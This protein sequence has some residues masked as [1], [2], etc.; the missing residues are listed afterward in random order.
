VAEVK[1]CGLMR[2]GDAELAATLGAAYVGVIFAGGPR[3][4]DASAARAV[5][6]G[7]RVANGSAPRRVGVFG[8]QSADEIAALA[9]EASLDVAQ[10]HGASHATLVAALRARFGGEIWR[11]LRVGDLIADGALRDAAAGVDAV[12]VDALVPGVLGGSGTAVDWARLRREIELGGRPARLVLAGG[13]HP[14]NV[15]E[16]IGLVGPDVVDVSSGV[17][18]APGIKDHVKMR[19]FAHAAARGGR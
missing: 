11:V 10:L 4:L 8:A 5:L 18:T 2:A 6:D 15:E 1:F 16:A 19:A 9:A 13:L 7:A 12:L 3:R 14:G 17:E